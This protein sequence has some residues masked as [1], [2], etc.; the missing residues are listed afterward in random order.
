MPKIFL[1]IMLFVCL[2]FSPVYAQ[3]ETDTEKLFTM[4]MD[5]LMNVDVNVSVASL[6][7]EDELLIGSSVASITPDEWNRLGAKRLSDALRRQTCVVPYYSLVGSTILAVRGYTSS[8]SSRGTTVLIDGIQIN[9]YSFSS[10][11]YLIP[12]W[13]LGTLSKIEMIKGPGSAIYGSDAFHG[14]L[15][16]KTF[17][18]ETDHYSAQCTGGYPEYYEGSAQISQGFGDNFRI[19][20]SAGYTRQGDQD[21]TYKYNDK[22]GYPP[23]LIQ[24]ASGEGTRSEEYENSTGILKLKYTPADKIKINIAGYAYKWKAGEFPGI[25]S[26]FT[27][28]LNLHENNMQGVE[29]SLSTLLSSSVTYN[30]PHK[31]SIEASGSKNDINSKPYY[32]IFPLSED[33]KLF[34]D[35]KL[36]T[37]S[38]RL[39]IK[40]PDN[41]LHIQWFIGYS[42]TDMKIIELHTKNTLVSDSW[43]E[44]IISGAHRVYN[45]I[46]TQIK[47]GILDDIFYILAGGRIDLYSGMNPHFTPRTGLIYLPTKKSSIKALYGQGF[48]APTASEQKA[49]SDRILGD[50]DIRPETIDVY[51]LI[52][53]QK[54]IGW[55]ISA[56]LFYS[57]WKDGIG[58]TTL[59]EP[60]TQYGNE[61]NTKYENTEKSESRGTEIDAF[62]SIDPFVIDLGFSYVVSKQ[63]DVEGEGDVEYGAYPAYVS[64]AGLNYNIRPLETSFTLNIRSEFNRKENSFPE[65]NPDDLDDYTRI[66][67]NITKI[68]VDSIEMALNIRNLLNNKDLASPSVTGAEYGNPEQGIN[69]TIRI[70]YIF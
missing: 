16:L 12:S 15:S 41:S 45:S 40:Q 51:E 1:F 66:D 9:D 39:L 67:L 2:S 55:R 29:G 47:W 52:Y 5:E 13:N 46:F 61:Y 32:N 69:G 24:P 4:S 50:P 37:T 28:G 21:I 48:S 42:Y 53:T 6:F 3:E 62:L 64:F 11:S 58:V 33:I 19:N 18:S 49:A 10:G 30:L 36:S 7:L 68:L 43:E 22:Y 26:G 44:D 17:E 54:G 57:I 65:K 20:A 23:L 38:G 25:S 70:K 56:S 35:I 34:T 59:E 8:A 31:I 63:L 60:V 14:V 27:N